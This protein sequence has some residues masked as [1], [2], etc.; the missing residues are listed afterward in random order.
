VNRLIIT[1][2]L[3]GCGKTTRARRWVAKDP[4]HRVRINRDDFRMM[5]H[6]VRYTG[7]RECEDL[8]TDAQRATIRAVLTSGVDVVSDDTWL[9]DRSVSEI[10]ILADNVGAGFEVWDMRDVSPEMCIERDK[11]RGSLVGADVINN[12]YERYL[13]P[14]SI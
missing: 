11:G 10:M 2:G 1:R 8:V 7:V 4:L 13:K 12:L 5:F 6:G 9:D 14:R 3:P